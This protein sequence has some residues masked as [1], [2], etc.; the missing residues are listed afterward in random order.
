MAVSTRRM[1]RSPVKAATLAMPER[2]TTSSVTVREGPRKKKA[3]CSGGIPRAVT[4]S[5]RW[6]SA[7]C[8]MCLLLSA[9]CGQYIA[10]P[11]AVIQFQAVE[12]ESEIVAA[13]ARGLSRAYPYA[14]SL[15]QL[16]LAA[17]LLTGLLWRANLGDVRDELSRATLW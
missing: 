11:D 16:A 3:A 7:C 5:R 1:P 8:T 17:A 10:A 9:R 15:V 12:Y 14:R 13:S 4:K 2:K 6:S